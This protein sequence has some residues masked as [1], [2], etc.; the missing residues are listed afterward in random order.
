VRGETGSR[1]QNSLREIS[2]K[3]GK[4]YMSLQKSLILGVI[5]F[6]IALF[7]LKVEVPKDEK[8]E[9]E[10]LFLKGQVAEDLKQ[11][12][13]S[14]K[15]QQSFKLVERDGETKDK[16]QLVISEGQGAITDTMLDDAAVNLLLGELTK[17]ELGKALPRNEVETDLS[18]YGLHDPELTIS[19][20]GKDVQKKL[21]FGALNTFTGDRYVQTPDTGDTFL[22]P[23]S[24]YVAAHKKPFDL[25]EKSRIN[26]ERTDLRRIELGN[27]QSINVALTSANGLEWK[28][29]APLEVAADQVAVTELIRQVR[30]L[31]AEAIFDDAAAIP[32]E[33]SRVRPDVVINLT[34]GDGDNQRVQKI[35]LTGSTG[36]KPQMLVRPLEDGKPAYSVMGNTLS[37]FRV[38]PFQLRQKKFFDFDTTAVTRVQVRLNGEEQLA[39]TKD[40]EKW[41]VNGKQGD[42]VFVEEYVETLA[43]LEAEAFP[44][45]EKINSDNRG[46]K[47][48]L[49]IDVELKDGKRHRLTVSGKR[50]VGEVSS[51][52]LVTTEPQTVSFFIS[53]DRFETLVPK[54]ETLIAQANAVEP[55]EEAA[56]EDTRSSE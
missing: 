27:E 24:V 55:K 16:W 11:L 3:K 32:Q 42:L 50:Q 14:A 52:R 46:I 30:G 15:S 26:F 45:A 43:N 41:T 23:N 2:W 17:L 12:I 1:G 29:V 38:G 51:S 49:E 5:L 33:F 9:R 34:I 13:V 31:R 7:I 47:T 19:V 37:H 53:E 21:I 35:A 8:A 18:V 10:G 20:D 28:V 48:S 36:E 25:R 54:P 4:N 39:L 44:D 56:R 40:Q 6:G 22:I